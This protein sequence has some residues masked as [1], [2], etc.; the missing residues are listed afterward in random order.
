MNIVFSM[1]LILVIN[2]VNCMTQNV[3]EVDSVKNN[4]MGKS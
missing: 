4:M 3:L 1:V 2:V